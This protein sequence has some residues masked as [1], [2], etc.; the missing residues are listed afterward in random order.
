MELKNQKI[1]VILPLLEKKQ[2]IM[3]QKFTVFRETSRFYIGFCLPIIEKLY[4][5]K[6]YVRSF[7]IYIDRSLII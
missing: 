1:L 7:N 4:S 3:A 2:S 5:Y 6:M